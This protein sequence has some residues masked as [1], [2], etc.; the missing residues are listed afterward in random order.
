MEWTY[1]P[2][3]TWDGL[4]A[5]LRALPGAIESRPSAILVVS[6]HWEEAEISVT[7]GERPPLI[8]DYHGFPEETYRLRYQAPGS[9]LLARR[10]VDLL[11]E[12]GLACRADPDRG[13]D[14]GVFVPLLVAYP[15]AEIPVLELSLRRDLDAGVHYRVGEALAPLREEGVLILGSGMSYHDMQGFG[16]SAGLESSRR[17]DAW[18]GDTLGRSPEERAVRLSGWREAPGGRASHPREEHL[19]PLMVVAGAGGEDPGQRIFSQ[20]IMGATISAF[21]FGGG[22]GASPGETF[23]VSG[24]ATG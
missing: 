13:F 16:T 17:F 9:P 10:I 18:L 6:A 15:E 5:W 24:G 8:Y 7:A 2:A 12:R 14:H 3:N 21:G 4:E 11:G 22:F 23:V 19:L 20:E 1:G